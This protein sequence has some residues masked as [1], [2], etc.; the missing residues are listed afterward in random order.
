MTNSIKPSSK[1]AIVMLALWSILSSLLLLLQFPIAVCPGPFLLPCPDPRITLLPRA[2]AGS[3]SM[4]H[5]W[6]G[7]NCGPTA[8]V[9]AT[10]TISL[11]SPEPLSEQDFMVQLT[12]PAHGSDSCSQLGLGATVILVPFSAKC[13]ERRTSHTALPT[14]N[15]QVGVFPRPPTS[16]CHCNCQPR[17]P[18]RIVF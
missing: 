3:G 2:L 9:A 18:C 12:L 10:M 15:L 6:P 16:P 11:N 17:F 8:T 7:N 13:R 4:I 5:Q 14:G 1:I